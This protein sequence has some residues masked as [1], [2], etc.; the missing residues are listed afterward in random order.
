MNPLRRK[1]ARAW[2]AIRPRTLVLSL[3]PLLL[4]STLGALHTGRIAWA[5]LLTALLATVLIQSGTNLHN[6]A[7]DFERGVDTPARSGPPRAAQQGWFSPRA[8]RRAALA[9]FGLAFALGIYLALRGGWPIVLIGLASLAAGYLYTGGPRPIAYGPWGELFVWLFFGVIAVAG[10]D[11]LQTL[12]FRAT[13]LL[14][15]AAL[16][17][18]AA[19]VLLLNNYRDLEGDRAA[20]RRTLVQLLGRPRAR[21]LYAALLI[22]PLVLM[23]ATPALRPAALATAGLLPVAAWLIL[24]LWRLPPGPGLNPLLAHTALYT[25]GLALLAVLGLLPA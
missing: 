12:R 3:A 8:I 4:G 2:A 1:L 11:Y 10:S 22:L 21:R 13:P 14:A 15:G 7:A 6:D 24:R 23:A 19:A 9:C 5:P 25:L 18:P 16:G 17:L 20:G